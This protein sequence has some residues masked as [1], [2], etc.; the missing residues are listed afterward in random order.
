[1]IYNK[2]PRIVV[3]IVCVCVSYDVSTVSTYA[4]QMEIF[5]IFPSSNT[6]HVSYTTVLSLLCLEEAGGDAKS[7]K[8]ENR[9]ICH[10]HD[11]FARISDTSEV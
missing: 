9:M 6:W 3:A 1:M 10:R 2:N 11:K 4:L 5:R 8:H 7:G